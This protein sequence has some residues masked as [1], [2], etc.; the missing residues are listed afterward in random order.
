MRNLSAEPKINHT[1][2]FTA[3][4]TLQ[5][6]KNSQLLCR[7][8]VTLFICLRHG[9][10]LPFQFRRMITVVVQAVGIIVYYRIN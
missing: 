5:P 3:S 1:V 4:P 8:T 9:D 6:I 2:S 7:G 10:V